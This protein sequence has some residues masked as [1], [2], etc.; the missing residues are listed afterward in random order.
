MSP[1]MSDLTSPNMATRSSLGAPTK[2]A[3]HVWPE[4]NAALA[5]LGLPVLAHDGVAELEADRLEDILALL[6]CEEMDKT[7][8]PDEKNFFERSSF[9]VIAGDWK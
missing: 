3:F 6:G 1:G 9:Q 2:L 8:L 5:A 4:T 7:I